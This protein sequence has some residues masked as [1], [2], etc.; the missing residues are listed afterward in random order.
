[1]DPAASGLPLPPLVYWLIAKEFR[2]VWK[3]YNVDEVDEFLDA[4]AVKVESGVALF[5]EDIRSN[6][7]RLG[8]KGYD[9]REVDAFIE[10]VVAAVGAQYKLSSSHAVDE[11]GSRS[12][13]DELIDAIRG[14]GFARR[15]QPPTSAEDSLRTVMFRLGLKGYNVDEVDAFLDAL[16]AKLHGGEALFP[17]DV[18][19]REFRLGFKGYNV[20]EVDAFLERFA[21][22]ISSQS[23]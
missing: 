10:G 4:L 2:L 21:A 20:D 5:P 23:R 17:E 13:S 18:T 11:D 1:M 8:L 7:F 22:M 12:P 6:E 14:L 19:S 15:P 3:G 9:R 16:A